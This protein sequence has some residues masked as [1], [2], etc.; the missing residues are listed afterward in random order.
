[1]EIFLRLAQ[2]AELD[3]FRTL[4]RS[5]NSPKTYVYIR[6]SFPIQ[7]SRQF[8]SSRAR[9]LDISRHFRVVFSGYVHQDGRRWPEKADGFAGDGPLIRL[10]TRTSRV[11]SRTGSHWVGCSGL[12]R[13][14]KRPDGTLA[15]LLFLTLSALFNY[16]KGIIADPF[17]GNLPISNLMDRV[18]LIRKESAGKPRPDVRPG[19]LLSG[20]WLSKLTFRE[21]SWT[22]PQERSYQ[23]L[24]A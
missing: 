9:N 1:M 7:L 24:P 21:T 3:K 19:L 23:T 8:V 20:T 10:S 15:S 6:I 17:P 16:P 13:N 22:I 2:A 4:T 14:S 12:R 11:R 5:F 18:N